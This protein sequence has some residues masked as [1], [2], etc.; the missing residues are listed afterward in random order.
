MVVNGYGG[1]ANTNGARDFSGKEINLEVGGGQVVTRSKLKRR[2]HYGYGYV[3]FERKSHATSQRKVFPL[4]PR[5]Q[6]RREAC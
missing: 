6:G 5:W 4:Y 2:Y 3:F 1:L